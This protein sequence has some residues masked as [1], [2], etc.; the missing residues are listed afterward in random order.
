MPETTPVTPPKATIAWWVEFGD[1]KLEL[2][3][4]D[5]IAAG[6]HQKCNERPSNGSGSQ[7]TGG[8]TEPL[9]I[10]IGLF[11]LAR[12]S[13]KNN[14]GKEL[15][16]QDPRHAQDHRNQQMQNMRSWLTVVRIGCG[17]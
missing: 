17:Q 7:P 9:P 15:R 6:K 8:A 2:W 4:L 5:K 10:G 13:N 14:F 12:K 1:V 3:I 11:F 16:H